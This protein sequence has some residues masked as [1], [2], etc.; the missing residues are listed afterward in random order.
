MEFLVMKILQC[1]CGVTP[2]VQKSIINNF[3]INHKCKYVGK[4]RPDFVPLK[5]SAIFEWNKMIQ[6]SI[7]CFNDKMNEEI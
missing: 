7:K 2:H 4:F 6:R 1:K 5:R 3:G